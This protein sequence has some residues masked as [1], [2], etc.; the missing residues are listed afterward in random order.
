MKRLIHTM[1]YRDTSVA[2]MPHSNWETPGNRRKKTT[3]EAVVFAIYRPLK[4]QFFLPSYGAPPP[5]VG[6]TLVLPIVEGAL[7]FSVWLLAGLTGVVLTGPGVVLRV[8]AG[9]GVPTGTDVFG[10]VAPESFGVVEGD[11]AWAKAE[12]P[13][14]IAAMAKAEVS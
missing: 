4:D 8:A 11:V 9:A 13:A 12:P 3:A 14:S 1:T 2:A 7:P 10:G 6:D 5:I